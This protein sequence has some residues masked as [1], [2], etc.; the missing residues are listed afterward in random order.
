MSRVHGNGL[1][2]VLIT[3]KEKLEIQE[4]APLSELQGGGRVMFYGHRGFL[5]T[6]L[7]TVARSAI[8]TW[9]RSVLKVDISHQRQ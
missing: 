2:S 6:C 7:L 9:Q 1:S 4:P 8:D 5:F 3:E